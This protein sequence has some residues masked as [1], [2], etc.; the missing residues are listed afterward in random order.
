MVTIYIS[1]LIDA[2]LQDKGKNKN[3]GTAKRHAE[4]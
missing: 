1:L 4:V 3:F 2:P